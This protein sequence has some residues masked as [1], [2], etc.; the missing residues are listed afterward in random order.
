[1]RILSALSR[2]VFSFLFVS[3]PLFAAVNSS[4]ITFAQQEQLPGKAPQKT[5]AVEGVVHDANGRAV[6]GAMAALRNTAT[7]EVRRTVTTAEGVLRLVGVPPGK[8]ELNVTSAGYE[9]FVEADVTITAGDLLTREIKL[10]A[11]PGS[12]APAPPIVRP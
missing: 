12:A 10:V 2:L 11:S 6:G 1:M 3:L 4:P 8:Y 7:G 9:T 5:G